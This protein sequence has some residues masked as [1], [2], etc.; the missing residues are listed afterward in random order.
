LK[1]AKII[2]P[3]TLWYNLKKSYSFHTE[4]SWNMTI[5]CKFDQI[6]H[7]YKI[8]RKATISSTNI[9]HSM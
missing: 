8:S 6:I 4:C 9:I 3:E 7:S 1:D 5:T 2:W